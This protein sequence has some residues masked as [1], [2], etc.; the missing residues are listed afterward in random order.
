MQ[1]TAN[2]GH[3]AWFQPDLPGSGG[4]AVLKGLLLATKSTEI[5]GYF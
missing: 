2:T 3:Q 5:S 4:F 1:S